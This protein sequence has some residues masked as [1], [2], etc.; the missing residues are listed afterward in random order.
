MFSLVLVGGKSSSYKTKHKNN[1]DVREKAAAIH[2]DKD[3]RKIFCYV[4]LKKMESLY[5]WVDPQG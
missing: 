2:L 4:A 5:P 3:H 1:F